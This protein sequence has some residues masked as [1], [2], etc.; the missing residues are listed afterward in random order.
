MTTVKQL[1]AKLKRLG[2]PAET[3]KGLRKAELEKLVEQNEGGGNGGGAAAASRTPQS[4]AATVTEAAAAA[5]CGSPSSL[6]LS[7]SPKKKQASPK[8]A[9]PKQAKAFLAAAGG[10]F[11][12]SPSPKTLKVKKKAAAVLVSPT[13]G[14]KTKK[15]KK[16]DI[17]A[18][19]MCSPRHGTFKAVP[20][21]W[22]PKPWAGFKTRARSPPVA[23]K[24]QQITYKNG[25]TVPVMIAQSALT[26]G[27]NPRR[28]AVNAIPGH[29]HPLAPG[30]SISFSVRK[31][32]TLYV[33][34]GHFNPVET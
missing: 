26:P 15:A 13:K 29:N 16:A 27:W 7:T 8:Q 34:D 31:G 21:K 6:L 33:Y 23:P 22:K 20:S 14:N 17:N 5:G 9:S 10:G 3:Y 12:K 19:K 25:H 32:N 28:A 4:P 24:E 30:A 18:M 1:K 2:V 11:G